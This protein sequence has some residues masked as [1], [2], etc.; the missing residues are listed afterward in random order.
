MYCRLASSCFASAIAWH[1]NLQVSIPGMHTPAHTHADHKHAADHTAMDLPWCRRNRSP[2][3]TRPVAV[4]P[5]NRS[6][7]RTRPVAVGP[8]R[9]TRALQ[10]RCAHGGVRL[11]VREP[12]PARRAGASLRKTSFPVTTTSPRFIAERAASVLDQL[13]RSALKFL[14]EMLQLSS[15]ASPNPVSTRGA[16]V[17]SNT[18]LN[19]ACVQ[20]A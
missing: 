1:P 9:V 14:Q 19:V 11:H 12:L 10:T 2:V 4:G 3:R 18:Y 16:A 17:V 13:F 7:V 6:L 20:Y 5:W 15:A 8:A